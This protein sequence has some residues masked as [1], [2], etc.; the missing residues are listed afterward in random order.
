M[1]KIYL[2]L[3]FLAV[4]GANTTACSDFLDREPITQPSNAT[5][6]SGEDQVRNYING[7]Y[8]SLPSFSTYGMGVRGEEK[9]SDNILAEKYDRRMNGEYNTSEADAYAKWQT[10]YQNLRKVNYFFAYYLVPEAE[11]STN[12]KS[13]KGEAYF[14]RAYWHYYLLRNFGSIPVMDAFWDENATIEGLQIPQRD[15]GEVADFILDD[16][17]TAASLLYTRSKYSG[18]RI[19]RETAMMLAMEVALYEGTWEKYHAN[20]A[21][22][23]ATNRSE[24][25]L[26]K[27]MKWGDELFK[28]NIRLNTREN[29]PFGCV[30]EGDAFAHLFNQ[31]DYS[32][33]T[34]AI[35]W[36]KYSVADGVFHSLTPNLA[37]GMTDSEGAAGISKELVDTYLNADGTPVNPNMPAYK[38]FNV[39]FKK[40]DTRL[41]ETV[42]SSGKKFKS[43][44]KGGRPLLVAEYQ[45]DENGKSTNN[46]PALL[47][48]SGVGNNRNITGF[49]IAL[50]VDSTYVEGQNWDTG[51][52]MF[53]YATALLNYAEAAEELGR[54]TDEVL[55]KTIKP[56]RERA[57]VAY[58]K[59][60]AIDPYFTDY[61]ML[62]PNL[63][64]IRRERRVELA[65]QGYRL[66]DLMRWKATERIMKS[67]RG[68]GAYLGEDGVLYK[69]FSKE[70]QLDLDK[71]PMDMNKWLDPLISFLPNGYNFHSDRD[72]LLPK[73]PDELKLNQKLK[74]N[75]GW[76][77]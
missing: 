17:N 48:M 49:H 60:A 38:D 54:C 14:L 23:A 71:L 72:Y 43:L 68:K 39:M 33:V 2:S 29:D 20:D 3:M 21:F 31:K 76:N 42:M 51:C 6:L 53:R 27:V 47:N 36:R 37:S 19:N 46:P 22:A 50:G 69:S 74:Q 30:N 64:E 34:E 40:R 4:V 28:Q 73:A 61:G 11:E 16:L 24:Y 52:I 12:V 35:F 25:F 5:F 13:L 56:L 58:V 57:G 59:P 41:T 15:R 7:L 18:L 65:L 77:N 66:D 62:T 1:K 63:Q 75:P 10:G 44:K 32:N 26:D 8:I 67:K 9:N 55:N 45:K 70:Q